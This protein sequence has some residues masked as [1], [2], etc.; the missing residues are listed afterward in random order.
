MIMLILVMLRTSDL[1]K[2]SERARA[3]R[4]RS[5]DN[6][7]QLDKKKGEKKHVR[8]NKAKGKRNAEEY[9]KG[10]QKKPAKAEYGGGGGSG[11]GGDSMEQLVQLAQ[12]HSQ[13]QPGGGGGGSGT[14]FAGQG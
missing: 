4:A 14:R 7:R 5:A 12:R 3:A 6:T 9:A 13:S 1:T 8:N 2:T 10:L 11:G